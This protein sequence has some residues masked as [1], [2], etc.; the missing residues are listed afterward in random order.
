MFTSTAIVQVI[1]NPTKI[2]HDTDFLV[3]ATTCEELTRYYRY[4]VL[5]HNYIRLLKPSWKSHITISKINPA[6]KYP[7]AASFDKKEIEFSY[8]P[9]VRYSGDTTGDKP[10]IHW[11]LDVYSDGI[12][13]IRSSLGL[14][15]YTKFHVTIG[16]L[17]DGTEKEKT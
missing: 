17:Q 10:P 11:F 16:I 8:E 13:E 6:D 12:R 9:I 5:K 3:T 2:K 7:V 14:P 4:L 15:D 1:R